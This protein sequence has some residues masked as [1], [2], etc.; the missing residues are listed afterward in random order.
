MNTTS[1]NFD[2]VQYGNKFVVTKNGQRLNDSQTTGHSR[3]TEFDNREDA[4]RY[5]SILKKLPKK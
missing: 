4:A 2:I 3:V 1:N 5:I